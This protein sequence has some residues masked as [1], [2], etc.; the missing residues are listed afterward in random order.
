[1]IN[2]FTILSLGQSFSLDL[3]LCVNKL[4]KCATLIVAKSNLNINMYVFKK[5]GNRVQPQIFFYL[6][7][8]VSLGNFNFTNMFSK[9]LCQRVVKSF[10]NLSVLCYTYNSNASIAIFTVY[11]IV[12]FFHTVVFKKENLLCDIFYAISQTLIKNYRIIM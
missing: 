2:F 6:K 9:S 3:Y 4:L 8:Q 7:T 11:C 5:D 10:L 12:T 1:M